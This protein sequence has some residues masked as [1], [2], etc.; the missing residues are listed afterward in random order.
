MQS[1]TRHCPKTNQWNLSGSRTSQYR[2]GGSAFSSSETVAACSDECSLTPR[3]CA[4]LYYS[5]SS[6]LCRSAAPRAR[7]LILL[8]K[9][10]PQ[11]SIVVRW[12]AGSQNQTQTWT[13]QPEQRV[14]KVQLPWVFD[15]QNVQNV[16]CI[17]YA[18]GHCIRSR[19]EAESDHLK[20]RLGKR[21]LSLWVLDCTG[22][23][24][25]LVHKQRTQTI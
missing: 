20:V 23:L 24:R 6:K 8:S 18:S 21:L 7:P 11:A 3:V 14:V 9:R 10:E 2:Q 12:P 1:V 19:L 13:L 5:E 17:I 22:A 4:R 16:W 25:L 15:V